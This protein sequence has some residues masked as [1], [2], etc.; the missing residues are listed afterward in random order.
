MPS[1]FEIEDA[2]SIRMT[3][4]ATILRLHLRWL[5]IKIGALKLHAS[6]YC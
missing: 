1:V 5:H 6:P 3:V 4:L 2:S